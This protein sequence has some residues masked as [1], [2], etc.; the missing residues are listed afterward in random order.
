MAGAAA[1]VGL[2]ASTGA[3]A[4][5]GS[6]HRRPDGGRDTAR[7]ILP[8]GNYGGVPTNAHS[9]DQLALYD[10][11]T[12][13]RD[14]ISQADI[15][16]H[17][18]PEDFTPIGATTEEQ[19]GRP[20]LRLL[21]DSYGIAHVYGQTRYDTAFGAGWA[22]ARD[23]LLLLLLGRGPARAAVADVPG[24]DAFSLVT[25]GQSFVPSAATE[26]LVTA[27]V[28]LII[29]TY[30][31]KGWQIIADAQA[32][33][34]GMNAYA[35]ANGIDLP[36]ATVNDI[37]ATTAFIGSIFGAG[38]GG[39]V[40]NAQLLA[41]L[42][43]AMGKAKGYAAWD[44]QSLTDDP[45]APTT[46]KRRFDYPALTG[47]RV[48]G[49]V[50]IDAGSVDALDPLAG[51]AAPTAAPATRQATRSRGSRRRGHRSG[52]PD[53]RAPAAGGVQLPR[54][55]AEALPERQH[56]RGDGPAARLLLPRDRPADGPARSG[57]PGPGRHGARRLDVRPHR[58]HAR[59]TRGA[60]RR[61]VTTSSTCTPSPC[62]TPTDRR[63]PGHPGTTGTRASAERWRRSTPAP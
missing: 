25:S 55:L 15:D 40:G 34:D 43:G 50:R 6:E 28:K 63:R 47:G 5:A 62:A 45:E 48:T 57:H 19:T 54:R 13:L 26:A 1:L 41:D 58:S 8:P 49:S 39:E 2:L 3:P 46:I 24:I 22:T 29:D 31:A 35:K 37:I 20:G 18:L 52:R 44:D 61:P 21:Y 33:A 11:L 42:E 56:A 32:N 36:K 30:G 7:Y 53:R 14:D 17:Y 12:P 59:T 38:G 23:R 9:T 27:Q 51:A 16:S 10:G 60:S 4:D